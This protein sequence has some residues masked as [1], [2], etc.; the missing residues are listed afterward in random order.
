MRALFEWETEAMSCKPVLTALLDLGFE[1]WIPVPEAVS[2]PEVIQAA[3]G[4]DPATVVAEALAELVGEGKV[5]IYRG[6]WDSEA[7]EPVPSSV[8]IELLR[9]PG[10]YAFHVGDPD[11]ERLYFVNVL[12]LREA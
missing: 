3:S 9:E 6:R 12:N 2:D 10:W 5:R 7:P 4:E 1:D 11:E 8:A